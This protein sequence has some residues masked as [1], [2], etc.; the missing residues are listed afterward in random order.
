MNEMK[1]LEALGLP[2]VDEI[3]KNKYSFFVPKYQRGYRWTEDQAK[4]LMYDLY[5]FDNEESNK[6]SQERCPF[7]SLQVLVVEDKGNN[8]FEVIDGQ[9]RLT[10]ILL[11]MQAYHIVSTL[12]K[13]CLANYVI[14]TG[15]GVFPDGMYEIK[16]ETRKESSIWLKELTLAY[17]KDFVD[18]TSSNINTF[19]SQYRDY[20][21][22]AEVLLAGINIMKEIEPSTGWEKILTQTARFIWY[23]KS[24]VPFEDANEMIFN[25][26]NATKIKLN[27]AELIKALFLQEGVYKNEGLVRRD[28][29]ALDW[30]GLEKKLQDPEFWMFICNSKL[31]TTYDTHIEYLFDMLQNKT[32]DHADRENYT[33]DCYY[34]KFQKAPDKYKFVQKEW[35]K[36][37]DIYQVL[38]EWYEER[39]F[40]HLTGYLLEYGGISIPQLISKLYADK[41][42]GEMMPKD[43]WL[44]KLKELVR[45]NLSSL[46]SSSLVYSNKDELT[47]ILFLFNIL[48]EDKRK[49]PNARFSFNRYKRIALGLDDGVVWHLE[50]IASHTD[51]TP[52]LEKRQQLAKDLLEYFTGVDIPI[53]EIKEDEKLTFR[54]RYEDEI[55]MLKEKEKDLCKKL[56][57]LFEKIPEGEKEREEAEIS[58]QGIFAKVNNF[59][60]ATDPFKDGLQ[61]GRGYRDEKDF[62]WNFVLLNSRTNMSYGN[63]IFPVKR[64]R[65][66]NDEN[67]VFTMFGTRNVFDKTYSRRLSN[68]MSWGRRDAYD[69]WMEITNTL[70]EYLPDNFG[71]PS[72]IKI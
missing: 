12:T 55:E 53:S 2:N 38:Q 65:I 62:I 41:D 49:N 33:F 25:R 70:K 4:K 14:N 71:L 6:S 18:G 19:K 72:Y 5:D 36:V 63:S 31:A 46:N 10:T 24:K 3:L 60:E 8:V 54:E 15:E 32:D 68:L 57:E 21:H 13:H 67:D 17:L 20:H 44:K 7:Y 64:R 69:Y 11:L 9:Q 45:E 66:L 47:R 58:L 42:K 35:K 27:N 43:Q 39:H 50:H 23:D 34:D 22:F 37:M 56:L 1:Q 30:D 52:D 61:F 59:F 29:M 26:L 48:Q 40:Y 51:Y 28:Q 16:Y